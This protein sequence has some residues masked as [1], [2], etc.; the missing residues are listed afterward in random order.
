MKKIKLNREMLE[1]FEKQK[2]AFTKKFGREPGP[3]DPIFFDPEADEPRFLTEAHIEKMQNEMCDLMA[4]V[5]IKPAIIYAYRKTGRILT[6][7]NQRYLTKAELKE[8]ESAIREFE[9]LG[10]PIN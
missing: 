4:K 8:W 10:G 2:K 5:G 7:E 6:A 1:A 3:N 9:S